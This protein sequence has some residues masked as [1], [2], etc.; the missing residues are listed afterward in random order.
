M[1]ARNLSRSNA[2]QNVGIAQVV[3]GVILS[4]Q[5][6]NDHPGGAG[7]INMA[8]ENEV[9]SIN[10][11]NGAKSSELNVWEVSECIDEYFKPEPEAEIAARFGLSDEEWNQVMV[12]ANLANNSLDQRRTKTARLMLEM[13][14]ELVRN[15]EVEVGFYVVL[16]G[17]GSRSPTALRAFKKMISEDFPTAEL[18]LD[19]ESHM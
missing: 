7:E 5:E 8:V 9:R 17:R 12:R 10:R 4:P 11:V 3:D 13:A 1:K 18:R 19:K 14:L 2:V 15:S 6:Y 16:T